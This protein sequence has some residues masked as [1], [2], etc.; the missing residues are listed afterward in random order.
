MQQSYTRV[1]QVNP[2]SGCQFSNF[3]LQEKMTNKK[4][5]NYL[6]QLFE[7]TTSEWEIYLAPLI[8]SFNTS[9]NWKF[10]TFSQSCQAASIQSL[11]L[12]E[13]ASWRISRSGKVSN[14]ASYTPGYSDSK[15][16]EDK[17]C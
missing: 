6:K 1:I 3:Y 11:K 14:F 8:L 12:G 15:D 4:I 9:S 13:E 17:E 16:S 10:Q 2:E 7:L 5:D